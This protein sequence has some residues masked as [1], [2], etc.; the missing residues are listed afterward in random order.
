MMRFQ[1]V[2]ACLQVILSLL[3]TRI[4]AIERSGEPFEGS[5]SHLDPQSDGTRKLGMGSKK[6]NSGK[7]KGKGAKGGGKG[8]GNHGNGRPG[9]RC[10]SSVAQ[11]IAS[12]VPEAITQNP[13]RC[14]NFV[15]PTA[16]FVTHS[17]RDDST[18]SNFER[19][20]D[21]IY[22]E[23]NANSDRVCFVMT[24]YDQ[25]V[26]TEKSLS[27]ILI[28]VNA[29]VS[30]LTDVPAIMTSDPTD[31]AAAINQIR[32][33]SEGIN[34][35]SIGV[36]NAGYKNLLIESLV[37]GK[38]RLPYIGYLDDQDFGFKAGE[39]SLERL[40]GI[41]AVPLCFNARLGTL[42]FIG[43][44]CAA[45]YTEITDA[46][47]PNLDTYGVACSAESTAQEIFLQILDAGANAV[48]SHVDCCD[49]VAQ[50][51][52]RVRL[53]GQTI[54][55]GCQDDDTSGGL[56]DFVTAQPVALQAYSSSSWVNFPVLQAM[57]Q[58]DG[59]G[60]QFFPSLQSLVNTAIFNVVVFR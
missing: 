23:I 51:A 26:D 1:L 10:S 20:W 46:L 43:E 15:G 45:Y 21:A 39:I 14:C 13:V 34:A 49:A 59:R 57:Q 7:G 24:G 6:L 35:P 55:V 25:S 56:V 58:R 5:T 11:L 32:M 30:T 18:N 41:P 37:S 38:P 42:D 44:R 36:F 31:S 8:K 4:T 27:E 16:V 60:E 2:V 53:L 29:F 52:E 33:I 9:E 28:A 12:E 40:D 22:K 17:Q 47:N 54:V 3:A 48:W 50:A 19:F